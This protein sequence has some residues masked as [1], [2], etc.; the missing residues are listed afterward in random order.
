MNFFFFL[1]LS[2][3]QKLPKLPPKASF[4]S[5]PCTVIDLPPKMINPA[6]FIK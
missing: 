3:L 2:P 1:S 6:A 4:L 5:F